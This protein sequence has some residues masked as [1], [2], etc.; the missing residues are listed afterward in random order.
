M[1]LSGDGAAIRGGRF[2]PIGIPA[3]YLSLTVETTLREIMASQP[4][5]VDRE[6]PV[7]RID[8]AMI[9]TSSIPLLR[10]RH[11][12]NSTCFQQNQELSRNSSLMCHE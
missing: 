2:N 10:G 11:A 3:F 8:C 7:K 1:P 5:T 6:M 9:S 4:S 12:P